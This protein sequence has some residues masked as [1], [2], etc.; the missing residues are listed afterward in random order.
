ML[1]FQQEL[2]CQG[3]GKSSGRECWN[4]GMLGWISPWPTL[5]G[6]GPRVGVRSPI[7]IYVEVVVQGSLGEQGSCSEPK[8]VWTPKRV[9]NLKSP[10]A[11]PEQSHD[12]DTVVLAVPLS[13]LWGCCAGRHPEAMGGIFPVTAPC[14]AQGATSHTPSSSSGLESLLSNRDIYVSLIRISVLLQSLNWPLLR[15]NEDPKVHVL[16]TLLS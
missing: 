7:L 14:A 5:E 3:C 6:M 11:D 15:I 1:S 9:I 10:G 8:C 2:L 12:R 13:L 16:K 4:V